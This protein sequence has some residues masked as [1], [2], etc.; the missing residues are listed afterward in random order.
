MVMDEKRTEPK[1]TRKVTVKLSENEV[2][3][4]T[5]KAMEAGIDLSKYI[6]YLLKVKSGG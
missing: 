3:S 2:R 6:R 1:L 5:E 4:L